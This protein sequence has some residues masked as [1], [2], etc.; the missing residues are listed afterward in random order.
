M[1]RFNISIFT[2][3]LTVVLA[4]SLFASDS[5][6]YL[7]FI[8]DRYDQHDKKLFGFLI[9]ELE[10]Y[11]SWYR[12]NPER[13]EASYLLAKVYREDGDD[14]RALATFVKT[15]YLYPNSDK[16]SAAI[17]EI[18]R[19]HPALYILDVVP[20][21]FA[22]DVGYCWSGEHLHRHRQGL[23]GVGRQEPDRFL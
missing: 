3:I 4:F 23:H 12:I 19:H 13:A 18:H 15:L 14:H 17:G 8:K 1:S 20:A 5:K 22:F 2:I 9:L 6:T 11:L 16:H 7:E 10:N 21:A